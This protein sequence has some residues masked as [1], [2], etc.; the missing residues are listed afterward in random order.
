MPKNLKIHLIRNYHKTL[1]TV[2]KKAPNY[3][4][5]FNKKSLTQTNYCFNEGKFIVYI[6]FILE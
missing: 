2:I 5:K 1:A 6:Y 4:T 3:L